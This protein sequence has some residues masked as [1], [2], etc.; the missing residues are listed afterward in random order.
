M[1]VGKQEPHPVVNGGTQW[2]S[3]HPCDA[4]LLR[5]QAG[6]KDSRLWQRPLRKLQLLLLKHGGRGSN[7]GWVGGALARGCLPQR[8][9]CEPHSPW[10]LG[11]TGSKDDG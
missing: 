1:H 2:L 11:Q 8:S 5:L 10:A 9:R 3:A 6:A 4:A 7:R